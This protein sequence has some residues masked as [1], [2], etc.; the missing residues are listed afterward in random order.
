MGNKD[1]WQAL[2]FSYLTGWHEERAGGL[3]RATLRT[4][5]PVGNFKFQDHV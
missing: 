4:Y 1:I 2:S 3:M 5:T